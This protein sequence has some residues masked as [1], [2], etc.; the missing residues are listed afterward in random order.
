MLGALDVT[1]LA[2]SLFIPVSELNHLRQSAIEE[3]TERRNWDTTARLSDREAKVDSVIPFVTGDSR[4]FA[5][6]TMTPGRLTATVY[7][8]AD[9]RAFLTEGGVD[10]DAM[11]P[12]VEG[13]FA[14]AFIR[15]RRPEA[16][17]CCG[18]KCCG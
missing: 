2:E 3:L 15:A 11:A 6:L 16:K 12:Q 17:S 18:P 9:A 14:S 7:N 5:S 8:V 13:K 1:G 4:S 10:V